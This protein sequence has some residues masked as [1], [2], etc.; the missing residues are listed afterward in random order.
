MRII[1]TGGTGLIGQHLSKSFAG[2][3]H[4]VIILSRNPG[5]HTFAQ[6]IRAEKWDGVSATG[7]GDL[8]DG[9]DV[10]IN[11]A[12]ESIAGRGF[13]P[14]RWT[15]ARK[16]RILLSRLNAGKAVVDAIGAAKIKPK[17]LIQSSAIG[18]YGNSGDRVLPENAA[19]GDDFLA[20]VTKQW[21]DSSAVVASMGVRR[22]VI[23]TG[24]VFSLEGGALPPLL[25]PFKLF[26]GGPL[27]NG[28]QWVP[29]I[30][31]K[32]EIR[33]IRFLV[34][35][36]TASGPFNLTAPDPQK[37]KA[38][39]KTIGQIM[40]RP[41]FIPV[42][43][44]ALKMLLGEVSALVLDGQR[45]VPHKLTAAGFTFNYPDVSVAL[46]ILLHNGN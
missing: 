38:L 12:G 27:G 20:D 23:R 32:D 40:K 31:I 37:N 1:I 15:S 24:V 9:A 43:A 6:G 36:G 17:V 34:D 26:V 11:L 5:E 7:W 30:H 46:Q 3:G 42:P 29:W 2:D 10:I 13:P 41:S 28:E 44:F 19:A 14:S 16:E 22:V 35:H 21:E 33:A 18:Y 4:E 39:A 45:A 8:A 25:L